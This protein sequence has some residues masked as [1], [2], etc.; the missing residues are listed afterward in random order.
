M[1]YLRKVLAPVAGVYLYATLVSSYAIA[2]PGLSNLQHVFSKPDRG[3]VDTVLDGFDHTRV[4]SPSVDD[5]VPKG[6][7]Q[8]IQQQRKTSWKF[9]LENIAPNGSNAKGAAPGTVIASPSRESPNY[10]YQWVRDAAIT[11]ADVIEEYAVT[12]DAQLKEI[13]EQYA[14]LQGILQNTFNPSG[15]YTTGGLGEPK[16]HVDGAPFTEHWG[17]PQRDGPALRTLALIKYVRT[18]NQTEPSGIDKDWLMRLYDS[19]FPTHSI[20]KADLEYISNAWNLTGFDLWEEVDDLHFYTAMVQHKALVEGQGLAITLDDSAAAHWY[21]SQQFKLRRFI[22][23][24]FWSQKKGH[25]RAFLNTPYRSGLDSALLLASLHAGQNDLFP[26]WSDEILA[27]LAV[28]VADNAERY[29]INKRAPPYHAEGR[30]RGVGVGRY[31]EDRYDGVGLSEGNPWFLCTSTVSNI[32]YKTISQFLKQGFFDITATNLAF[33]SRL[34]PHGHAVKGRYTSENPEYQ[35]YLIDMFKYADSFL[36][37]I[38]WHA[39][40]EGRL[41]E[42]FNKYSGTQRGA[43]DLTWSYGS[44]TSA[45]DDRVLAKKALLRAITV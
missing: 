15:G 41:S 8:W 32:M 22:Q 24:S 21:E 5:L 39:T 36:N 6:L 26:P 40:R 33:F 1:V 2:N 10:Y 27:S 12:G 35:T 37:V 34:H 28:L 3:I 38:R 19:K 14:N 30:L 20:I 23:T 43:R 7:E 4:L 17:R 9:L 31:P 45:V 16:F 44:F 42:Q 25:L 11:M 18:L 29:P 13:I